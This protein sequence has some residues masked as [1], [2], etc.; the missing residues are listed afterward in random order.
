MRAGIWGSGDYSGYAQRAVMMGQY[1]TALQYNQ[2]FTTE[3]AAYNYGDRNLDGVEFTYVMPRGVEPA[4]ADEIDPT[5]LDEATRQI[6]AGIALAYLLKRTTTPSNYAR[7][8]DHI[9]GNHAA[10]TV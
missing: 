8:D 5:D 9:Y 2:Q 7:V 6:Q 10:D 3:I 1:T 4:F